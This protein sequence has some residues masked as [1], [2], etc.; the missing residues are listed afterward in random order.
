M[1]PLASPA[2][3]QQF[4]AS[5]AAWLFWANVAVWLGLCAYLAF[6]GRTQAAIRRRIRR[7]ERDS[8]EERPCPE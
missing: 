7:L 1:E 3:W 2:L 8:A 6:L 4:T 5:P